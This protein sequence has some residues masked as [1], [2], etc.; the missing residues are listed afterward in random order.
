MK[1][2]ITVVTLSAATRRRRGKA[3]TEVIDTEQIGPYYEMTD[4]MDIE[5]RYE[6]LHDTVT[7]FDK[8]V[9]VRTLA[10]SRG[11]PHTRR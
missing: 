11:D 5:G 2:L 10:E 6:E 8:V 7:Q 3:R 9:D 4:P 1:F